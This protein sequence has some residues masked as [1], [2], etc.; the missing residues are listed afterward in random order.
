VWRS[1]RDEIDEEW[2]RPRDVWPS[3]PT[4]RRSAEAP[5][6][7]NHRPRSLRAGGCPPGTRTTNPGTRSIGE[8]PSCERG[9][10]IGD[11]LCQSS[12]EPALVETLAIETNPKFRD[13]VYD[14]YDHVTARATTSPRRLWSNAMGLGR[15]S[16]ANRATETEVHPRHAEEGRQ[17]GLGIIEPH[18]SL[19]PPAPSHRHRR[20][21]DL[22][23]RKPARSR[24][25]RPRSRKDWDRASPRS[26]RRDRPA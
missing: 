7:E 5:R 14:T 16:S 20:E 3:E 9:T 26:S 2:A 22:H 21:R 17:A 18:S 15:G 13:T 1:R 12:A 8:S 23:R 6:M 25:R 19:W 11:C 24:H 4:E 10:Q